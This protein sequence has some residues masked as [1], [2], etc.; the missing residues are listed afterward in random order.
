MKFSALLECVFCAIVVL[1]YELTSTKRCT[2]FLK[3][4]LIPEVFIVICPEI[5][6]FGEKSGFNHV[7]MNDL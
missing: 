5:I 4:V 7:E 6:Y 1:S 3:E 2:V